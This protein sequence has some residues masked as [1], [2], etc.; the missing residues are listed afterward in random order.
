MPGGELDS[1][2]VRLCLEFP[3][4]PQDVVRSVLGDSYEVVV[5]ATG[6]PLLDKVEE[7]ARLR[8]EV[9]TGL[10]AQRTADGPTTEPADR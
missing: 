4:T 2:L 6:Q 3:G 9:R 10:P 1:A 7:L 5:N 8:L